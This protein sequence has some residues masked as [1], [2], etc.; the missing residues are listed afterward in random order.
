MVR[1]DC[2]WIVGSHDGKAAVLVALVPGWYAEVSKSCPAARPT[3]RRKGREKIGSASSVDRQTSHTGTRSTLDIA[4]VLS[5]VSRR[6]ELWLCGNPT[7]RALR[8]PGFKVFPG[9]ISLGRWDMQLTMKLFRR[10][11][12][13]VK[14]G[15][16]IE[17]VILSFVLRD[18]H[19]IAPI[20]FETQCQ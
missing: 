12:L 14:S 16:H 1:T 5:Q 11:S 4:R 15:L 2:K 19:F 20:S 17:G 3:N 7:G 13:H 6:R 8:C 18:C 9:R 10:H